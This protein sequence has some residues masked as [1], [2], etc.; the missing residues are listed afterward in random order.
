MASSLTASV[1]LAEL[2]SPRDHRLIV[3][4]RS[5]RGAAIVPAG[6]VML[7]NALCI[8]LTPFGV[9]ARAITLDRSMS[10]GDHLGHG[11]FLVANVV[12]LYVGATVVADEPKT[13]AVVVIV[14]VWWIATLAAGAAYLFWLDTV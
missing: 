11:V 4:C 6:V 12:M 7:V 1:A 5:L 10:A 8:F 13:R 9:L 2:P 14:V 3:R